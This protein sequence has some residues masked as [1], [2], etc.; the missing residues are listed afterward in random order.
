M[1]KQ[2]CIFGLLVA[3]TLVFFPSI[4][5]ADFLTEVQNS[6]QDAAAIG[7]F[8]EIRQSTNQINIFNL[9]QPIDGLLGVSKRPNEAIS[10]QNAK[11]VAGTV[12]DNN[13]IQQQTNQSSLPNLILQPASL[14][15]QLLP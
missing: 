7:D 3:T 6:T 5:K 4:A 1:L 2:P 9:Q 14:I 11:Q 13:K 12:G 10:I 8:N 15:P